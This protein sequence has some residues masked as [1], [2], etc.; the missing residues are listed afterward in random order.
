MGIGDWGLGLNFCYFQAHFLFG[1]VRDEE[2][3]S[4]VGVMKRE[5]FGSGD[6][7]VTEGEEGE[8]FYV[9]EHGSCEVI[10]LFF[11]TL[12]RVNFRNFEFLFLFLLK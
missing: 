7:I 1:A 10:T 2:L 5:R 4:I 6:V 11:F 12:T 8:K 9:L 3:N